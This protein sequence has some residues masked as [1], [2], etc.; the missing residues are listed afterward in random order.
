MNKTTDRI[1]PPRLLY[2]ASGRMMMHG[3]MTDHSGFIRALAPGER[4]LGAFIVPSFQRGLVWTL[5]QKR[6]LIESIYKG[7]PIGAIVWNQSRK[8]GPCDR[9]LL[10][11]QQR[12]T[13]IIEWLAGEFEV[14]GW[15]YPE[16]PEIERRHFDRMGID[17]IQTEIEDEA[18][19]REIYDRLVYGGT[20]HDRSDA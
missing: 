6:R 8:V 15:R 19:C 14:A 4:Y 7:L 9:W 13:A 17:A 3:L 12:V 11:G 10:D 18:T 1:M 20:P 16:L 5:E 2:G